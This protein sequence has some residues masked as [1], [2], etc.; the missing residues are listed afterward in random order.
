MGR[1]VT[2]DMLAVFAVEAPLDRLAAAL[3]ERYDGL[4]DR[5]CPYVPFVPGALDEAWHSIAQELRRR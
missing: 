5:V 1:V 2:D 3:Q 4:L